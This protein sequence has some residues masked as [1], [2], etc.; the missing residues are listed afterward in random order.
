MIRK[1]ITNLFPAVV[2]LLAASCSRDDYAGTDIQEGSA[3]K[4]SF[5]MVYTAHAIPSSDAA[6]GTRVSTSTDGNYTS[7]WT[8][9]DEVGVY[10]VKGN[11]GLQSSGNWV[12]NMKMTY[13]NGSWT[14]TFPSGKEYYPA[15]GDK[16]NFY[17]YYPYNS[18]VTDALN[19]NIS[20]LT[21]QS[22]A[23]NL[24]KSDLLSASTLNVG[25]GNTTV[26][27]DFSHALTMV[28]LSVTG[29]G[30]GAQMSS[31]I[32]VTLDGCKPDMSFNLSTR[33]AN[34]SG[35]V[36]SVKMYRVEQS[37]DAN[38]LTKYTY[39]ALVPAQTVFSRAELFRF[40][41]TQGTITR[42]LSHKLALAVALYP[43]QVK[44]YTITLQLNIDP[45]HVYTVGDYYP[46][47][48]FPILGV[49]FET[50]NGGK[51][52]KIVD[53]DYIQRYAPVPGNPTAP[54]R[55]GD[56]TADE[57][58]AGVGGIRDINDGYNGTRNLIIMYKDQ[59]S[60]LADTYC[61]FNWIYLTKNNGNVNG[62]WYL[63]AVNEMVTIRGLRVGTLNP[64]I[65]AAG[66]RELPESN[67]YRTV[68]ERNAGYAAIID[69]L[70][71]F[72]D[73][74]Y[75]KDIATWSLEAV[76]VGKF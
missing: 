16:L 76:A 50:S 53:L 19:M 14:P 23:A 68:T 31:D 39:R 63:P 62:M 73:T 43:G 37:E 44:P 57:N 49:V 20:G 60:K 13:N 15:D 48:G 69:I 33:A 56:P 46:Y 3:Q 55:W 26:Q 40:S 59:G 12:D 74:R 45:N 58:A 21:D 5:E 42:V 35:S 67:L 18:T 28:E 7:T 6:S 17:A 36:K 11:G 32:V 8:N 52:G 54:I 27:L 9:G 61:I 66:G 22:S 1:I 34:A 2:I 25:K 4:I 51:N 47:K 70:Y 71:N 30:T 72:E 38:Y 24:S 10:I 29:G 65:V 64:K 41:Q 75:N